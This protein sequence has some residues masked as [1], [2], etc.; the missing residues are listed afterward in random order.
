[1]TYYLDTNIIIYLVENPPAW[2]AKCLAR[3]TRMRQDGDSL[4]LSDLTRMECRVGP[5]RNNDRS[6]LD[7]FDA[8]FATGARVVPLTRVVFDRAAM[9]RARWG[10]PSLDALHL[11]AAVES[12]CDAFL[13]NDAR[14]SRFSDLTVEILA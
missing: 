7:Q 9:L 14:L 8:F 4:V 3:I 5:L 1:M 10:F 13:T 6:L 11:A 2:G 12:R